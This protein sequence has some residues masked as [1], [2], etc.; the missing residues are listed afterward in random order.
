MTTQKRINEEI[1]IKADD[2]FNKQYSDFEF[3]SNEKKTNIEFLQNKSKDNLDRTSKRYYRY[4]FYGTFFM[5]IQDRYQ[6][7]MMEKG[8]YQGRRMCLYKILIH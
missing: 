5:E 2:I 6:W 7:L 3:Y 4:F 8:T 1:S